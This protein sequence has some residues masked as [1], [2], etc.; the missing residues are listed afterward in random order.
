MIEKL[1][2]ALLAPGM[3]VNFQ[4]VPKPG[5]PSIWRNCLVVRVD[6]ARLLLT[7]R[8]DRREV[9]MKVGNIIE[10]TLTWNRP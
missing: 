6:Q 2:I 7:V 4:T 1:P 9:S 3:R 5:L 8:V 10:P